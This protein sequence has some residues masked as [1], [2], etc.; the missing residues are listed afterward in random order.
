MRHFHGSRYPNVGYLNGRCKSRTI[1]LPASTNLVAG[2]RHI[3]L[4]RITSRRTQMVAAIYVRVS[5]PGQEEGSSLVS[6]ESICKAA[7]E[8]EGHTVPEKF[9]WRERA[10]GEDLNRDALNDLRGTAPQRLFDALYVLHS[11]RLSRDPL[12]IMILLKEFAE[13][14]IR[15]EFVTDSLG[16]TDSPDAAPLLFIRGWSA[17]QERLRFRERSMLGRKAVAGKRAACA[18]R[19]WTR[20]LRVQV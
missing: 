3:P 2:N 11:D 10:S 5:T 6:Q 15:V 14:G 7:A 4:P 1:R 16:P 9:I 12:D 8:K 18:P 20:H 17:Q 19:R 13:S